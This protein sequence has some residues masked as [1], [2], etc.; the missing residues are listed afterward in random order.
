EEKEEENNKQVNNKN[1][2]RELLRR[3]SL[4]HDEFYVVNKA[5]N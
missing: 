1:Q 5:E 3:A 4:L 2:G